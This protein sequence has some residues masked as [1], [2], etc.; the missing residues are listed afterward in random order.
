MTELDSWLR[1]ATRQLAKDAAAQVRTEIQQHYELARDAAVANGADGHEADRL[2]LSVLGDARIANRDYRRVLLTAA[3]AR[4][5]REGNWEAGA[6]CRRPWLRWVS[7]TMLLAAMLLITALLFSGRR[8]IAL[9]VL[10]CAVAMSP[11][12]AALFLPIYSPSR[13]RIFRCLRLMTMTGAILLLFGPEAFKWSW[14]LFSCLAP[15]AWIEWKR[16]SIRR[17]LPVKTWPRHLYL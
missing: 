4:M 17:K 11:L 14:L 1:Q 12:V 13:G 3:E 9:D 16:A 10:L 5:L 15:I 2:A 8:N 6:V 7:L